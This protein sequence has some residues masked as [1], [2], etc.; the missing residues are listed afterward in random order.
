MLAF[1]AAVGMA[2]ASSPQARADA[3]SDIAARGTVRI[4]VPQDFPPFGSV[5]A[6]MTPQ[7]YDVD[8]ANLIGEKLGAKVEIVPVTSANRIPY[9]QTNKVDLVIS[10]LGKNPDREKVIDFSEAYA[11][12]YNGVFAPADVAV[13]KADDLAGKTVGVTRGAIED[14]ELTKV[15][16]ASVEIKRYE[17][18][19]GTI[20]AFL[21]GQV[22]VIAT[23]NVVAAAILEKNPPKRPELKFLIKNS[24]CYIGM[25]KEQPALMAKINGIIAAA[26]SDGTL[27]AISQKWLKVDLPADL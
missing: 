20:S 2:M 10:S 11:P 26:R 13:G 16:P 4:A 3:L 9:L 6:D 21:S 22:E 7:G 14:L 23:G 17:D 27:N 1:A 25:N 24:P 18:N 12:F 15:V 8:I 19:N 5:G